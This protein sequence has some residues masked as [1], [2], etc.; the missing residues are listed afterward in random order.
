MIGTCVALSFL[1]FSMTTCVGLFD[2]LPLRN[3]FG[4]R[5]NPITSRNKLLP[6]L[7]IKQN[8]SLRVLVGRADLVIPIQ[9]TVVAIS[10]ALFVIHVEKKG[11]FRLCVQRRILRP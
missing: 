5:L 1:K 9:P 4:P 10:A 3:N 8:P 11:T 6:P 2:S 7:I